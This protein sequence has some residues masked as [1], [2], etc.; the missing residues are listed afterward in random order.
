MLVKLVSVVT[1]LH[2]LAKSEAR[3]HWCDKVDEVSE[4]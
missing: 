4:A 2:L 1:L 3:N